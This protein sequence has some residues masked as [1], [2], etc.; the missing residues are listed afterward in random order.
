M[1]LLAN[2]I[3]LQKHQECELQR[4]LLQETFLPMPLDPLNFNDSSILLQGPMLHPKQFFVQDDKWICC[5][6]R[7]IPKCP[8]N[9]G[10]WSWGGD[11][12][13][14]LDIFEQILKMFWSF[15]R[16]WNLWRFSR[17]R[18]ISCYQ[19]K[20]DQMTVGPFHFYDL[21]SSFHLLKYPKDEVQ[22]MLLLLFC[23]GEVQVGLGVQ[24]ILLSCFGGSH[25]GIS[26][27]RCLY[28]LKYH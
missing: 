9:K 2:Q 23:H 15:W 12:F 11:W 3:I 18:K 16:F 22:S 27:N 7:V 4:F 5:T 17:T 25:F 24:K 10:D 19:Q 8:L 21:W 6:G 14:S 13:F 1:V 28:N 26:V 20:L